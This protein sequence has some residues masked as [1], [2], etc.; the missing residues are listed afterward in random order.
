MED[1]FDKEENAKNIY[2]IRH[3]LADLKEYGGSYTMDVGPFK[4]ILY[5]TKTV[6]KYSNVLQYEKLHV[7][8]SEKNGQY[9]SHVDLREDVRFKD[10]KP[11]QYNTFEGPN[12]TVNFSDGRD[13]P[14]LHLCELIKLLTRLSNLTAFM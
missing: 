11:I 3:K 8:L 10:Y 4:I 12:G 13:M 7:T 2:V 1:I 14:I 6:A 9:Y 5:G